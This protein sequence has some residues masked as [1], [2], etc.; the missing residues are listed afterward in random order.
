[1]TK[2]DTQQEILP[3]KPRG[4]KKLMIQTLNDQLGIVSIACKQV[5]ISRETHYRWL[6]EDSN[7]KYWVEEANYNLKD[8]GENCLLKSMRE[9]HDGNIW[10]FNKTINRDRG[11]GEKIGVEHSGNSM[12]FQIIEKSV[13]EIKD[14]KKS[15]I[16]S[17]S[18]ASGNTQS[19]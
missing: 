13:E 9:G 18:E 3:K 10:N 6:R 1:M 19:P 12:T 5:G 2:Y 15:R 7:Y 11:Y 8:F 17:Q 4:K 14:A 16:D